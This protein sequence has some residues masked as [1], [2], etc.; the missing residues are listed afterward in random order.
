M[1]GVGFETE[2]IDARGGFLHGLGIAV[3]EMRR[4]ENHFDHAEPAPADRLEAV[5]QR[6]AVEAAG[7]ESDR[8]VGHTSTAS[9]GAVTGLCD[10]SGC[11]AS[12]ISAASVPTG[13]RSPA[14]MRV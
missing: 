14:N 7:R 10:R 3:I 5:N 12:V 4:R 1:E 8:P 11:S 2:C 9:G 6:R 13:V